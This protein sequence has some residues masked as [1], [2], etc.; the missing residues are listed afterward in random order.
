M[1]I[2]TVI[3]LQ[4]DGRSDEPGLVQRAGMQ[5]YRIPMTTTDRPT[6]AQIGQFFKIVT[7]PANDAATLRRSAS[8]R[9]WV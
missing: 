9:S 8:N 4:K 1:G 7:D 3:D 5:F 2:K 6:E